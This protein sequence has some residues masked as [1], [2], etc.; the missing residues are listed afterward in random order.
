MHKGNVPANMAITR[1]FVLNILN[2]MKKP[3]DTRPKLM[4]MIGWDNNYLR[5]FID[6]L[7]FCS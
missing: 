5:Q 2:K 3:R 7:I 1:R 6:L 4:C